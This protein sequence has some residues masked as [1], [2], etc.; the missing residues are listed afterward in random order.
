MTHA[1][2]RIFSLRRFIFSKFVRRIFR[3]TFPTPPS[4]KTLSTCSTRL[5][6][7]QWLRFSTK[8]RHPC[9]WP[10]LRVFRTT[11]PLTELLTVGTAFPANM[12]ARIWIGAGSPLQT[13]S[14]PR[15]THYAVTAQ[16]FSIFLQRILTLSLSKGAVITYV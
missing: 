15:R 2:R 12:L 7:D 8:T 4:F 5:I 1:M 11:C 9:Y 3:A 13:P 14:T 6:L 16:T 10:K